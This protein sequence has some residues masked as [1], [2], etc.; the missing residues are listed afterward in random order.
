MVMLLTSYEYA[1]ASTALALKD[2]GADTYLAQGVKSNRTTMVG[3]IYVYLTP[4][5]APGGYVYIELQDSSH[6]AV[7]NGISEGIPVTS[8]TAGW[9]A[10][11]FDRDA[12]PVISDSTQHYIAL[13]HSGYTYGASDNVTWACDQST[14][15][16]I[17]GVGK[18]YNAAWTVIGTGTDFIFRM[19]SGYRTTIY[20]KLNEVE[21]FVRNLT[22][23]GRFTDTTSPVVSA[24]M[25]F[26][27]TVSDMIDGWL[28][29]AGI[30]APLSDTTAQNIIRS[31]ANHCVALECEMTQNTSG[32][33]NQS[34]RTRSGAFKI[35]CDTLRNDLSAGGNVAD[36]IKEAQDGESVGGAD[37][38]TAGMIEDSERDDRDDD[39]SLIQP[40]F[41]TDMWNRT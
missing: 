16:Y 19:Y 29:G 13:K 18:T 3:T 23:D 10:F 25:D 12:R 32:F 35:M 11:V 6:T 36:A 8:L 22:L 4:T 41:K 39:T 26:E 1:N 34:G 20:S 15:H 2:S 30:T 40:T 7:E 14:P 24:V 27:D 17:R 33:T 37:G 31:Y 38:L 9:N 28:L 5:G 21:S